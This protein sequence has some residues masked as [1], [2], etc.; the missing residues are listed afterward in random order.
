MSRGLGILQRR[1]C[2]TLNAAEGTEL[3]LRELRRRLGEPDRSNLRRGIRGLLERGLVEESRSGEERRVK[4]TFWGVVFAHPLPKI[5]RR[6]SIH[7]ELKEEMRALKEA[8]EEER[9]RLEAEAAEGPRW[10]GYEHRFVRRRFPGPTQ[11]RILSVLW[12]YAD[13]LDEGLPATAVKA[14]VGGNRSN[15]RRAIRTLL[16]RGQLNESEDGERIRLSYSAA[17]WFSYIPPI[18]IEP[19]DDERAREILRMHQGAGR[20]RQS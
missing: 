10:I 9:R 3:P 7:T 18:P 1:I 11:T 13:P 4:L 14:I 2:D 5:P 17:F 19:I 20:A 8:R 16:L 6:V 12:E 15:T